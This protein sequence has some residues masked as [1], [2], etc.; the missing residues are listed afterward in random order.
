MIL[1]FFERGFTGRCVRATL[2]VLVDGVFAACEAFAGF[3]TRLIM[4]RF[5]LVLFDVVFAA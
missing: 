2:A 4:W 5:S 3:A 1:R